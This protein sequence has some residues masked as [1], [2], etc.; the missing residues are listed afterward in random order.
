M[1]NTVIFLYVDG[2]VGDVN[3]KTNPNAIRCSYYGYAVS[4]PTATSGS[5][6]G[7]S[8]GKPDRQ[9][10]VIH[11]AINHT[12][13]QFM[14]TLLQGKHVKTATIELRR[15]AKVYYTIKMDDVLITSIQHSVPEEGVEPDAVEEV[16]FIFGKV[17]FKAADGTSVTDDV[18]AGKVT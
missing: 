16:E 8:A 6:S 12:S 3:S 4:V 7:T 17:E 13:P 18:K 15:G 11:K 1:T 9:P 2:F 5:G 10:I 14:K